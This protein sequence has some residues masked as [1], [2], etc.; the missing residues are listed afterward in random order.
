MLQE[1]AEGEW[2]THCQLQKLT[3]L[4]FFP[5]DGRLLTGEELEEFHL[6]FPV[7]GGGWACGPLLANET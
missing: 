5:W 7:I 6:L 3:S 1:S 4:F 2:D